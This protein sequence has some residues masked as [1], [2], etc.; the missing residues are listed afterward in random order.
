MVGAEDSFLLPA[1]C[2]L[3]AQG[4]SRTG[5]W[6]HG[7]SSG[8]QSCGGW[9]EGCRGRGDLCVAQAATVGT[10]VGTLGRGSCSCPTGSV[11]EPSD[12]AVPTPPHSRVPFP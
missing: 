10:G 3:R 8:A 5:L 2:A 7:S 6:L 9:T 11:E 12:G 1:L 4:S